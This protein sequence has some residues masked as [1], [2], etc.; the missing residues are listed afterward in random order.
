MNPFAGKK[1][2][3]PLLVSLVSL[4]LTL[5][6]GE[7]IWES[8]FPDIRGESLRRRREHYEKVLLKSN[9]SWREALY[10][11]KIDNPGNKP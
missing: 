1:Q 4:L 5:A 11:K 2:P 10:Y 3:F 9:L 7:A 8:Y 6:I